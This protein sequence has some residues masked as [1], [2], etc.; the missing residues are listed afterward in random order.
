MRRRQVTAL[1]LA[2]LLSGCGSPGVDLGPDV[3]TAGSAS[4]GRT[5]DRPATGPRESDATAARTADAASRPRSATAD[6]LDRP[7]GVRLRNATTRDRYA[8]VVVRD[9]DREIA[10]HSTELPPG[11]TGT[12]PALVAVAG[13]YR[14]PATSRLDV[15]VPR[16]ARYRVTVAG[17]GVRVSV[18]ERRERATRSR[19]GTGRATRSRSGTGRVSADS[20][21]GTR[22]PE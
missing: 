13:R 9:G 1:A 10:T 15:R 20:V 5:G 3:G 7:A 19:S 12:V 16:R 21:P 14:V 18:R 11:S 6:P 22:D 2:T 17:D 4:D 8:T